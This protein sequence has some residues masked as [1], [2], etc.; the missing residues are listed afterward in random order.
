MNRGVWVSNGSDCPVELP[1]VLGGIQCAVT[2]CTLKEHLGPYLKEEAM[3]AA[4]AIR[5]FT[6][7]SAH[8]SFEENI[9]GQI[10]EGMLADF[11]MLSDNPLTCDPFSIN[12]IQV[13]KTWMNGRLVYSIS[14]K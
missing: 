7:G 5:S 9:K 11:V 12:E 3:S 6:V 2:R 1:N 10:K 4:E 14:D 13:L 8:A